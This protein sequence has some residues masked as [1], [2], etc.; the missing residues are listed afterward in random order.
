MKLSIKTFTVLF[1]AATLYSCNNG[2]TTSTAS[3]VD[4]NNSD[5][6]AAMDTSHLNDTSSTVMSSTASSPEQDFL[7]FAIPANAKELIWLKA[8]MAQGSIKDIKEHAAMMI[9]DHKKLGAAVD[10]FMSKKPTYAK[11]LLDTANTITINDKTGAGWDKAWVDK[12][13]D[14]HNALLEKLK[15]AQAD[16]TDADL[17]KIV[18]GAIPVVESHVA[19][20][21]MV[22]SKLK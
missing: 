18:T 13:M 10:E 8:G 12:M 11:P 20:V 17:K 14:D 15:K 5:K 7:N 4:T 6:M 1:A 9:K 2:D 21:K 3:T 22:Q 19:M 16:V